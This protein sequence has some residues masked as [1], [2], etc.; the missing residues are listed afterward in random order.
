ML[1]FLTFIN[2]SLPRNVEAEVEN[3]KKDKKIKA[4]KMENR[5][6]NQD[7]KHHYRASLESSPSLVCSLMGK[8]KGKNYE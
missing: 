8:E 1:K 4:K 5:T 6:K 7:S 3:E 2:L